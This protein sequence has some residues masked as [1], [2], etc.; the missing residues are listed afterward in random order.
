MENWELA[1]DRWLT[2]PPEEP[3]LVFFC[4]HCKEPFEV[5]DKVYHIEGECLCEECAQ[6]WL[7]QQVTYATA[8]ECYGV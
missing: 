2:T 3:D 5:D 4:E 8:E 1:L 6:E 7:H